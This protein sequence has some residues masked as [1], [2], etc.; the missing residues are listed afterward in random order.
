LSIL[1][2]VYKYHISIIYIRRLLQH[3]QIKAT[4]KRVPKGMLSSAEL[5]LP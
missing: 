2:N 4:R 3:S 5:Y 1:I